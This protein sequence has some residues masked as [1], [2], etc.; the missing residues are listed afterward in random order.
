[1][2][3][4]NSNSEIDSITANNQTKL[5]PRK[6]DSTVTVMADVKLDPSKTVLNSDESKKSLHQD[7][8]NK[9]GLPGFE[10]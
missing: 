8:P 3:L 4:N 6:H 9:G 2:L 7:S 5:F 10:N 1:M